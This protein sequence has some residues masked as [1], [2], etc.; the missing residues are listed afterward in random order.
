MKSC[1]YETGGTHEMN[2]DVV[3]TDNNKLV[4][5]TYFKLIM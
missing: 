2:D 5:I 3:E 4:L 1:E